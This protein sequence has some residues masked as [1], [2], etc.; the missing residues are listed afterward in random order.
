LMEVIGQFH[1]QAALP[2]GI[3]HIIS[4]RW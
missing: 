3:E 2:M 4:I 1:A